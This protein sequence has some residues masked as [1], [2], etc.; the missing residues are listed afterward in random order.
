[1]KDG[2]LMKYK[3]FFG[4]AEFSFED[5]LLVGKI[6]CINDLVNYEAVDIDG[7]ELAFHEAVDDYIQTCEEIGKEPEKP[8]SGTFNV[9]VGTELHKKTT[10]AA[11]NNGVSLNDFVKSALE[12]ALTEKQ[13]VHMHFH[14]DDSVEKLDSQRYRVNYSELAAKTQTNRQSA[15]SWT[16][17]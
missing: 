15:F 9:R 2:K 10:L 5:R 16:K 3:G 12:L 11:M 4:S 14:G 6:E 7:L 1:M 13:E 8:F 17:H